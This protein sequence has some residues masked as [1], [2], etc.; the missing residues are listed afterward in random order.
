MNTVDEADVR[1]ITECG[2]S[3]HYAPG[4]HLNLNTV[5]DAD[6]SAPLSSGPSV[7]AGTLSG[8]LLIY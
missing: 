4:P 7:N 2:W 1:D 5:G 3:V 6:G 8:H